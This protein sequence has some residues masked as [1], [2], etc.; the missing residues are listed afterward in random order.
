MQFIDVFRGFG[1]QETYAAG[2]ALYAEAK[3]VRT[4]VAQEV[5]A[6][7]LVSGQVTL[8]RNGKPLELVSPGETFGWTALISG[9]TRIATAIARRDSVVLSLTREQVLRALRQQPE[10][11][12]LIVDT[13][14]RRLQ[15]SFAR[16]AKAGIVVPEPLLNAGKLSEV[17]ISQLGRDLDNPVPGRADPGG[18]LIT[19]DGR[20]LYLFVL[21]D[22]KVAVSVNDQVVEYVGA[23]A[24]FGE[25][26][27][28]AN[29][30]RAA[31]AQAIEACEWISL[32]R[33][34][35]L[36]VVASDPETGL[37]LIHSMSDRVIFAGFLLSE[38]I[39]AVRAI[40]TPRLN[41]AAAGKL[42]GSI[43]MLYKRAATGFLEEARAQVLGIEAGLRQRQRIE[44]LDAC[45]ELALAAR[46]IGAERFAFQVDQ[47]ALIIE[48]P[49]QAGLIDQLRTVGSEY[50][51][52]ADEIGDYLKKA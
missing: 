42:M 27:L 50:Q 25:S 8:T 6:Y 36:R 21:K 17:T 33:D 49:E 14:Y 5:K 7:L 24:V 29:A 26:V 37:E 18:V 43:K 23:G 52:T 41:A 16:A 13:L 44:P 30:S 20:G 47:L 19:K 51:D 45:H 40:N 10:F 3:R 48:S 35:F 11:A 32:N 2:T 4:L 34:D 46:K 22:G 15:S 1:S 38:P 28:L 39:S 31:S 12:V 9:N